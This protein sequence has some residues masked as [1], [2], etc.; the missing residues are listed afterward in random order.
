M[1][2]QEVKAVSDVGNL[3]LPG[4]FQP[5]LS[6]STCQ[7][8]RAGVGS[9]VAHYWQH[10]VIG[11]TVKIQ[12]PIPCFLHLALVRVRRYICPPPAVKLVQ[13]MFVSSGDR[14]PP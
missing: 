10:K 13:V 8:L 4:Q 2:A 12:L 14:M 7:F 6:Q 1:E 11:I 9:C 5:Q 3:A